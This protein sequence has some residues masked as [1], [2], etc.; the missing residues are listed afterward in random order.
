MLTSKKDSTLELLDLDDIVAG[1]EFVELKVGC[2]NLSQFLKTLKI[3]L[4]KV[5]R[6]FAKPQNYHR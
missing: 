1:K 6:N 4:M 5:K 2:L 3:T